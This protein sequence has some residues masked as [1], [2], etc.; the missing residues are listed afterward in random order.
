MDNK[1]NIFDLNKK[2]VVITGAA[3]LLGR[4]HAEAVAKHNGI[5]IL[6]DINKEG[7]DDLKNI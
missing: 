5:P 2:L 3:G 6:L 4:N 7:L 1:N